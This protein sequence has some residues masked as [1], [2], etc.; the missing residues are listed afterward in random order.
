[1]A[2]SVFP[3]AKQHHSSENLL[4]SRDPPHQGW[5]S[6]VPGAPGPKSNAMLQKLN[7]SLSVK[8]LPTN[9]SDYYQLII[10]INLFSPG[11]MVLNHQ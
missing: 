2:F 9:N 10:V 6:H 4:K 1:M 3:G 11:E 8:Q 7:I 5:G